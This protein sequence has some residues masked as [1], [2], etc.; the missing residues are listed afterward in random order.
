MSE[1]LPRHRA[2]AVTG[3]TSRRWRRPSTPSSRR[4]HRDTIA[5]M[6]GAS[7]AWGTRTDAIAATPS[8]R[9]FRD[10]VRPTQVRER[11]PFGGRVRGVSASLWSD[12][13]DH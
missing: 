5:S 3:K 12:D 8:T 9:Q 4:S 13:S 11:D 10:G 1:L 2:D 6:A 7:M